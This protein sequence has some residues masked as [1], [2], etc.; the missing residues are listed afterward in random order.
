M[1]RVLEIVDNFKFVLY[2]KL[3]AVFSHVCSAQLLFYE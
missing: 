2:H 3:Q 1:E